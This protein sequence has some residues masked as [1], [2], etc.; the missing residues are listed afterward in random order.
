MTAHM[1]VPAIEPENIPATVSRARPHWLVA[2]GI[3]IQGTGGHRRHGHGGAH[4]TVQPA[5]K[6][7]V[8][9]IEAGA[10]V[11]LMPPDPDAVDSRR[12]GG[13]GARGASR[14]S[15]SMRAR[16]AFWKPRFAL[17]L[18]KKKIVDL[19]AVSDALD[20][21]EEAERSQSVADRALTLVRNNGG[22]V[23]LVGSES[24]LPGGVRRNPALVLR[25]ATGGGISQACSASP[26]RVHRQFAA[27]AALDAV[28]GDVS[29]CSALVFATFTTN[30]MLAGDLPGLSGKAYLQGPRRL[31]WS[32]SAIRI[33]FPDSP[34]LPAI[35][36]RSAP[37]RP[38]RLRW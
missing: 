14:A 28:T 23:P 10:D 18:P 26:H 30:P 24:G 5:A 19:D 31:R 6:L 16:C 11:L 27:L 37:P 2:R 34:K 29:T 9:A 36:R 38:P 13:G 32:P 7:S 15:A 4:E 35:W 8:R 1:T 12:D 21:D 25:P 20:S 33:C 3:G 17:G 22:V